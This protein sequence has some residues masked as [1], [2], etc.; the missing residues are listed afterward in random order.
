MEK[1]IEIN[2]MNMHYSESGPEDAP[3]VLL[4]HGWLCNHTTVASIENF[5]NR[6]LHVYNLDLPG[7]GK[8]DEPDTVW[9]VEENAAQVEDFIATLGISAPILIGHSHGGRLAIK[10]A[11]RHPEIKKMILVDAAGIKPRRKLKYYLKVYSFKLLKKILPLIYGKNRGEAKI[12]EM[13]N[14]AGSADYNNS[15]QIMK[16][17]MSRC[18]NED[19]KSIMPDIKASTL[20]VWGDKDTATPLSDAKMMEKLI[21]DAGVVSFENCGHYSFLDNPAGFRAVVGEFLKSEMKN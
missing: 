16:G 15:S 20:L 9:G 19:L 1:D 5:L 13:R 6:R 7:H 10:I 11:S 8:T 2:G 21:P 14:K 18:V 3:S 12:A 4:M 17:V